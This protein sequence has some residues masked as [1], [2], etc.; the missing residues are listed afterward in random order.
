MASRPAATS[1]SRPAPAPLRSQFSALR[2][3]RAAVIASN[4]PASC[5]RDD[6]GAGRQQLAGAAAQAAPGA[7]AFLV[8]LVF[9]AAVG[10]GAEDRD[11]GAVGAGVSARAGR[12]DQPPLLPAACA[13]PPVAQ[14]RAV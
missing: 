5:R 7:A 11:P 4:T 12:G 2:G 6:P 3:W 8:E 13:R 14:R 1:A 10:A 9:G